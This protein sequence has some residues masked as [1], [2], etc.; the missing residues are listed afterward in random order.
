VW[1]VF[2]LTAVTG[3]VDA[4]SFV[5][6]GH[7]FVANMTGNTVFVAFAI[8]GDKSLSVASS[9]TAF[10]SFAAGAVLGGRVAQYAKGHRGRVLATGVT[11]D[12]AFV[13]AALVV[14][15][16]AAQPLVGAPRYACIVLLAIGMG[17]Q[18]ATVRSVAVADTPST[19]LTMTLTALM[20]DS[21]LAGGKGPRSFRRAAY[22]LTLFGGALV[23]GLLVVHSDLRAALGLAVGV[24]LVAAAVA[25]GLALR[26][27]AH[28]WENQAH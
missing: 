24:L 16:A 9:L 15:S 25:G 28:E 10:G 21:H 1:L 8:A 23:G 19:V 11:L 18:V 2:V 13:T 5:G 20:A 6:I 17:V 27:P 26:S 7:V 4:V 22:V 12:A 3:L 14:A